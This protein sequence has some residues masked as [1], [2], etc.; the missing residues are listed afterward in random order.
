M[1]TTEVISKDETKVVQLAEELLKKFPPATTPVVEFLGAQYDMGLAWVNFPVGLGGLGISPK[2][3][4]AVNE[5]LYPAGAPNPMYRNPIGHGMC[6]P[7]VVEWGS[8]EQK[9]MRRSEAIILSMTP[10]ERRNP[11]LVTGS[12][13]QRIAKGS[14]VMLKDVNALIKQF[15]QMRDMM[16]MMKGSKGKEM[17]K[18]MEAMQKKS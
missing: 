14:G 6:G 7:T 8:E 9:K 12:R 13:L 18:R 2:F 3:Q 16:R 15:H 10:R 5:V 17:M 4:K 1:S 11:Q